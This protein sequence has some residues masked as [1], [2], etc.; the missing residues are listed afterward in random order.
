M[1]LNIKS[2]IYQAITED[3]WLDVSYVNR[4]KEHSDYYIGIIDID[5]KKGTDIHEAQK[6]VQG[7]NS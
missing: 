7:D 5:I 4:D 1:K 6:A 2:L 3:R